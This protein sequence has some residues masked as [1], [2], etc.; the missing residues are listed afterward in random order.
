MQFFTSLTALFLATMAL[1]A[2]IDTR[3]DGSDA[4]NVN[5]EVENVTCSPK[6]GACVEGALGCYLLSEVS[7]AN[8]QS[9]VV[10]VLADMKE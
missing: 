3:A 9:T 1:G 2:V 6:G 4:L 7:Q 10:T 5:K 8:N